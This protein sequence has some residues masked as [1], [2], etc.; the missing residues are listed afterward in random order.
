[1]AVVGREE[2]EADEHAVLG[3]TTGQGS[4]SGRRP[5]LLDPLSVPVQPAGVVLT[6]EPGPGSALGRAGFRLRNA[7][8]LEPEQ[9]SDS[10]KSRTGRLLVGRRGKKEG[11]A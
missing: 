7:G 3:R 9:A 11:T 2:G 1:V 4:G 6:A 5:L 8:R 10:R